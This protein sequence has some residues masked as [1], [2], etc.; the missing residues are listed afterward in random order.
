MFLSSSKIQFPEHLEYLNV[1]AVGETTQEEWADKVIAWA[2]KEC[3]AEIFWEETPEREKLMPSGKIK[4][5]PTWTSWGLI[6]NHGIIGDLMP[7]KEQESAARMMAA[8]F[9]YLWLK[10]VPVE[11]CLDLS[12]SFGWKHYK[13]EWLNDGK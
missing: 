1:G 6:W 3:G 5:F 4:K 10:K 7:K 11:L 8:M 9:M 12:S 13:K 2:E